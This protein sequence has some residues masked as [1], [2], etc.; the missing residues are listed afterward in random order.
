[1]TAQTVEGKPIKIYRIFLTD[2]R[3]IDVT[4][5]TVCEPDK[6]LSSSL[7]VRLYV[8]KQKDTVVAK[9]REESVIGWQVGNEGREGVTF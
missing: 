9:F 6:N 7:E 8:F 4:A 3:I 5:E 1:M 2:G